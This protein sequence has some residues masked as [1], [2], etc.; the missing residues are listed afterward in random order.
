METLEFRLRF[1]VVTL[2][3]YRIP[4]GIGVE[5]LQAHVDTDHAARLDMFT[6]ALGLNTKLAIIAIGTAQDANPF[7]L[8]DWEGFDLLVRVP[9]QAEATNA[10]AI[11]ED[12]MVPIGRELPACLFILDAPIVVLKLGIPLLAKLR[13]S[14]Q[15]S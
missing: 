15:F 10:T 13:G 1:S 7:D 9:N 4:V 8:L 2:V 3:L 5:E 11:G 14:R 12:D 6:L